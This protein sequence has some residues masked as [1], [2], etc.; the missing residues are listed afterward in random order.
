ML[1]LGFGLAGGDGL[2]LAVWIWIH[3]LV[4]GLIRAD[5]GWPRQ[6]MR[7]TLR[8]LCNRSGFSVFVWVWASLLRLGLNR[9]AGLVRMAGTGVRLV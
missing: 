9:W 2:A 8:L 7:L 6:C 3:W 4:A 1:W 5:S